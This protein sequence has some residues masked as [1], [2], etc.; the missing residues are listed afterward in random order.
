MN[1]TLG[2]GLFT[3]LAVVA[4]VG[5]SVLVT[6]CT[7]GDVA[8]GS[9]GQAL[10]K[11]KDGGPTGNGSTCSWLS[12]SEAATSS[13]TSPYKIGDTFKSQ[14]GC[15]ECSCTAQG[16]ACTER[17]CAPVDGGGGGGTCTYDGQTHASGTSFKS[18]DG[19][20][21]CSCTDGGR[22][23]CSL[24]A[25]AVPPADCKKTGCSNEI[26]SDHD[27]A[28]PCVFSPTYACYDT[29]TCERQADGQCG[30]TQTPAL[31]QCLAK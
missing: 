20:N 23:A 15:N 19:C 11:N 17:A 21:T 6:A 9:T 27:V 12:P 25:C 13:S 1:A 16:I 22:V 4:L 7:S 2:S 28:S 31:T 18:T 14:D 5:A 30:F 10:Q 26:C 29:A 3:S 24:L 8:V